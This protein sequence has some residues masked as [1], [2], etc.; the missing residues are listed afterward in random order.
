MNLKHILTATTLL[1]GILGITP[2]AQAGSSNI[3]FAVEEKVAVARLLTSA[4]EDGLARPID[5]SDP[6]QELAYKAILRMSG[7]TPDNRPQ[8]FRSLEETKADH[9]ARRAKNLPLAAAP[10][11][12][13]TVPT[14]DYTVL[15][16]STSDWQNVNSTAYSTMYTGSHLSSTTATVMDAEYNPLASNSNDQWDDGRNMGVDS[17]DGTNPNPTPNATIHSVGTFYGV[18][19]TGAS[20][21]PF[22][23]TI[24]GGF[25]PKQ[26]NN[27]KP[28]LVQNTKNIIICLNR[29]N[30]TK[31][32]PGKCDYGPTDPNYPP[33]VKIPV[34]GSIQ[35]AGKIDVDPSTGKPKPGTYQVTLSL[36]GQSQGGSCKQQDAS[37]AFF[38]DPNT[39]INGDTITWDMEYADFGKVCWQNDESYTLTL[40]L[41][42]NIAGVPVWS[43]ITNAPN[44]KPK[45]STVVSSPLVAQW[46]CIAEGTPVRL[47]DGRTLPIEKVRI[48]QKVASPNGPL[49]VRSTTHGWDHE[50]IAVTD[51]NNRTVTMTPNHPVPTGRGMIQAKEL[52]I[53]DVLSTTK[54]KV[55]VDRLS[56]EIRRK[57]VRV[58]NLELTQVD[59][60]RLAD[61]TQAV[62]YAGDMLVGDLE[63]QRQLMHRPVNVSDLRSRIRPEWLEDFDNWA[64][65]QSR[66]MVAK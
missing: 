30:P 21:G 31:E 39:K 58:Y 22:Y 40:A 23:A 24:G 51:S 47:S 16:I 1:A 27:Q 5:L 42:L 36:T 29:A 63:M 52:R 41:R 66:E 38:N 11:P 20:Y 9:K 15:D 12:S 6:A 37:A 48:G 43:T 25:Y 4:P 17:G 54:D 34:A 28:I 3:A 59:G 55:V 44:T 56:T 46:G 65:E 62:F 33:N 45:S 60:P 61:P 32:N 13:S 64:K 49:Q 18:D 35:Y 26:I 57:A 2:A 53:G 50:V 19:K 10:T 8:F 14:N 7:I